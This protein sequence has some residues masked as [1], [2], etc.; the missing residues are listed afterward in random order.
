MLTLIGTLLTAMTAFYFGTRAVASASQTDSPVA[1]PSLRGIK[2]P[3]PPSYLLSDA[4]HGPV[5]KDLEIIGDNLNSIK[6][7]KIVSHGQQVIAT[8]VVSNDSLVKCK[9]TYDETT[10]TGKWDVTVVD[11]NSK[12]A[13]LPAALDIQ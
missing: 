8:D 2:T 7:V 12:T 4:A 11:S 1:P 9:I 13:T 5:T 6:Q 3:S 10:P